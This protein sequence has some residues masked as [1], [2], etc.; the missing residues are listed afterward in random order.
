MTNTTDNEQLKSIHEIE[1]IEI[2]MQY[3]SDDCKTHR[4]TNF[5]RCDQR[6]NHVESLG[7]YTMDN[8][9]ENTIQTQ[10]SQ[11]T[12]LENIITFSKDKSVFKEL[13]YFYKMIIDNYDSIVED[14]ICC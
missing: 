7:A 2:L 8:V 13:D 5:T 12:I 14:L 6:Q 11:G 3:P 1:D 4:V 10:T 9:Y